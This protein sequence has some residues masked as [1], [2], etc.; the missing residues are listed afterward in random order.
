MRVIKYWPTMAIVALLAACTGDDGD[1]GL[2]GADGADGFNSL[3]ATRALPL[4]DTD[5]PGGGTALDSGLDTN[6]DGVLDPDEVTTSE[7]LDCATAPQLRA[8]HASPDAPNVNVVVNGAAA[9]TDVPYFAGSA[10]LPVTQDID[11][12]VNAITPTGE[13][14]VIDE[15]LT[16]DFSTEYTVVAVGAVAAPI[17]AWVISNPSDEPILPGNLRAQ[18]I[19]AAPDAGMWMSLSL[20]RTKT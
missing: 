18:V 13:V 16:L 12:Q 8:L 6:R 3:V 7:P 5:C 19:H 2:R 15:S 11:V 4:G 20:C 17:S 14:T 10:F 9:L 1:D